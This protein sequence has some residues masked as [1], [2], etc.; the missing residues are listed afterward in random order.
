MRLMQGAVSRDHKQNQAKQ[1]TSLKT[2]S[3][4]VKQPEYNPKW[5]Y[6]KS[7]MATSFQACAIIELITCNV[8][9]LSFS[10]ATCEER[11]E[12]WLYEV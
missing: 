2:Q 6:L 10:R 8:V 3:K 7:K 9:W 4:L 5:I 1:I 12:L 11:T